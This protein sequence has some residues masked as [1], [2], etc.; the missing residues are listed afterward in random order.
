MKLTRSQKIGGIVIA[1][2]TS[3]SLIALTVILAVVFSKQKQVVTTM[4]RIP[5]YKQHD[6]SGNMV[7][8]P[9]TP[10][11]DKGNKTTDKA[12]DHAEK[13]ECFSLYSDGTGGRMPIYK[14]KRKDGS[15]LYSLEDR[16]KGWD[17][18][19]RCVGYLYLTPTHNGSYLKPVYLEKV[20][21]TTI[22]TCSPINT[23]FQNKGQILGYV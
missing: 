14:L 19:D 18:T 10:Y 23:N 17:G 21:S 8:V 1:S 15:T 6:E 4:M 13:K 12:E 5:F 11:E 2:G 16:E 20:G 9:G 7:L 22:L 3:V